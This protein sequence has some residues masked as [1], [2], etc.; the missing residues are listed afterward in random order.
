MKLLFDMGVKCIFIAMSQTF[1][2]VVFVKRY[3][4]FLTFNYIVFW[5]FEINWNWV[6]TSY[7]DTINQCILLKY[8]WVL[9]CTICCIRTDK[10]TKNISDCILSVFQKGGICIY[11]LALKFPFSWQWSGSK[12]GC[13]FDGHI[14]TTNCFNGWNLEPFYLN[15]RKHV[16]K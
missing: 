7:H 16:F 1:L 4:V 15:I 9:T 5:C 10:K 13:M 8:E 14:V 11:F 12:G 3:F 6:F 2:D